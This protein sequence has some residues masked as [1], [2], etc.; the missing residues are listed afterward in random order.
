MTPRLSTVLL[1]GVVYW[2]SY[3]LTSHQTVGPPSYWIGR[4]MSEG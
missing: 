2:L 3:Q 4:I 1:S